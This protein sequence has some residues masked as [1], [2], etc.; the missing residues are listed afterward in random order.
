MILGGGVG[1]MSAAHELIERGFDVE[2]FEKKS[3]A[4]GKARSLA[5][6][7]PTR[8]GRPGSK[9]TTGLPPRR[10]KPW[11]PGEHG[12]R[13]FPRFYKHVVH[14][15]SRIPFKNGWVSDNLVDTTRVHLARAGRPAL[16]LPA[17]FPRAPD[18][19]RTTLAVGLGQLGG[20][21]GIPLFET[22]FFVERMWQ[23]LTSC[24]ER[25][26]GE[27]EK[28]DWWT[29]IDAD[30]RLAPDKKER[31]IGYQKY[32]G[33]AI[34]RSLVAA[35]AEWASTKTIGDIFLQIMF[36]IAQPGVSSDR[37]LNGPTNDVWIDPWLEYLRQRGVIYHHD[38]EVLKITCQNDRVR[39]VEVAKGNGVRN[40]VADYFISALPVE[41]MAAVLR[42]SPAV[43]AADPSLENLHELS[44]F[45]E[46]MN[47]IQFYL[48]E[49]VP[50]AP[51]HTIFV[52]SPW[53]LTSVSQAQFWKDYDLSEYG[54]G[55]VRGILSVD[56]SDWDVPGG[57]GK[58]ADQ[59]SREEIMIETWRQMKEALNVGGAEVLKDEQVHHWFLD[60]GIVDR[61]PAIPGMEENVEPLLVN[62]EDTWRLRPEAVTRIS[63]FFLA[64]DYVRTHT[65]L[66][67]MEAANEAA[68]RAVNGVI[69][70]AGADVE[71]CGVWNLHEPEIFLPF[72]AYDRL[73]Y[74]KGQP[75][76]GNAM[77]VANSALE[78][79]RKSAYE[80]F[81]KEIQD[82][83]RLSYELVS[84]S[85][86]SPETPSE[87]NAKAATELPAGGAPTPIPR[88]RVVR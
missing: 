83:L 80:P 3:I 76:D 20:E 85:P 56:I 47:G 27:Y 35:K 18:D 72:R 14:T 23:I 2:V 64:S 60:P 19:L 75:W 9:G 77:A 30:G 6:V 10:E 67:T 74:R 12:F 86:S 26:L 17:R 38:A 29:F 73:R 37:V 44:T 57:N 55:N 1:G 4:G 49:D 48:K 78:I 34:T 40:V 45:V 43:L 7:E 65:D 21:L 88:I 59:C 62:Y 66:A 5:V 25:R 63:N 61:D 13:F 81:G 54:D 32:F 53:A 11:L 82:L 39:S 46:W 24:E 68:R 31:S 36:D 41:R 84:S 50:L 16:Q 8:H 69:N 22:L 70:H 15:M 42:Q 52:D 87:T 33:N 28:I 71:R 51:G 79:A 58:R